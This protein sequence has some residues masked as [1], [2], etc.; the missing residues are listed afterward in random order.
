MRVTSGADWRETIPFETPVNLAEYAPGEPARCFGCGTDSEPL[1]REELQAYKHRHP[2][3]HDGYV[4][5]Y[6]AYHAPAAP[7]KPIEPAAAAPTSRKLKASSKR[8][9]GAPRR[10][11][12]GPRPA[13]TPERA[14]PVCPD[15]FME[16][17]PTGL[18]GNCG[19][20]IALD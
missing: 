3:N 7:A 15:C 19:K 12:T 5:F 10:E 4:R 1:P 18:C 8:V 13:F 9:P 17:P 11:E 14:R 16:I 6:C 20:T 2:G